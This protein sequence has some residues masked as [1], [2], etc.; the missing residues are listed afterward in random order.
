MDQARGTA[1]LL[2]VFGHAW[3]GVQGAGLIGEDGLFL[4][5]DRL[6]YSFHMPL[7]FVLSGLFLERSLLRAPPTEVLKSRVVRLLWPLVLWSYIFA[8]FRASAGTLANEPIAW[9]DILTAPFPPKWHFWFL[10]ALFVLQAALLILRPALIWAR[11]HAAA[12]LALL[13]LSILLIIAAPLGTGL[14]AALAGP[15]LLHAPFLLLGVLLGRVGLTSLGRPLPLAAAAAA[16]FVAAEGLALARP[17]T[18]AT[19]LVAGS[20]ASVATCLLVAQIGRW[21]V[22]SWSLATL[23]ILGQMSMVIFLAHTIFSSAFRI[24][25]E[26]A[27]VTS[28]PLHVIGG[29]AV[30]LIGPIAVLQVARRSGTARLLGL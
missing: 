2:V 18:L 19:Y 11:G 14:G 5:V 10:W 24:A 28:L 21:A 26:Q 1:I 17:D 22:A 29:T 9:S 23:G 15:A 30:G 7:F 13:A 3:R 27:G 12:W 16:A 25:L 6:I 4:W 20:V 8:I